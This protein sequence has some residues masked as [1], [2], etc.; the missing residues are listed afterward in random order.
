MKEHPAVKVTEPKLQLTYSD[1]HRT[2]LSYTQATL[3]RGKHGKRGNTWQ[4]VAKR[5]K[6]WQTWQTWQHKDS[7][8]PQ[9]RGEFTD[10]SSVGIAA[11]LSRMATIHDIAEIGDLRRLKELTLNSGIDVDTKDKVSL[12]LSTYRDIVAQLLLT[13][14]CRRHGLLYTRLLDVGISKFANGSY[15]MERTLVQ[16]QGLVY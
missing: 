5:G 13:I 15:K 10:K 12:V 11:D 9:T 14:I 4:N 16:R 1:S 6:T 7:L 3:R 2:G 8:P